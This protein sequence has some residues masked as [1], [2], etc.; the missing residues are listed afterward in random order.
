MPILTGMTPGCDRGLLGVEVGT[1]LD[2]S[3]RLQRLGGRPRQ[4]DGIHLARREHLLA[5]G[6]QGHRKPE[7]PAL[8][9]PAPHHFR[10]FGHRGQP[11]Y[12]VHH[13]AAPHNR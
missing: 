8:D 6:I 3:H 13:Q 5:I 2:T 9:K 4:Y 11:G 1:G 12:A 10:Q 7:V